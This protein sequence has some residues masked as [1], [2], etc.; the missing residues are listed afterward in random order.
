MSVNDTGYSDEKKKYSI[1]YDLRQKFVNYRF[2]LDPSNILLFNRKIVI[3][4]D[5][6]TGI[7]E[8]TMSIDEN[9]NVVREFIYKHLSGK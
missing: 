5:F 2:N 6:T 8:I 7:V 1:Q 3:T 9:K 4:T